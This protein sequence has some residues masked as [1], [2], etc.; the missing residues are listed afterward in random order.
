[1]KLSSNPS[2]AVALALMAGTP[3]HAFTPRA[4]LT[5]D[6][7]AG[8]HGSM[9]QPLAA[10]L[11]DTV[12]PDHDDSQN[13]NEKGKSTDPTPALFNFFQDSNQ[14]NAA[15]ATAAL[16]TALSMAPMSSDAAMTGGR[17]GGA[18]FSS[19]PA[20]SRPAPS[21]SRGYY[22][23]GYYSRP[24]VIAPMPF[25]APIS[26]F[27]SP[28]RYGAPGVISYSRG[29]GILPLLVLGGMA[30]TVSNAIGN[31]FSRGASFF[32][33]RETDS[34]LGGGTSV[35][36]LSVAISVADRDDPNSILK[37]LERLADTA[38]T[39]SRV[40][41]Q[42]LSSQ[43]AVEL[44]R[45]KASVVAGATD[46]QHYRNRDKAQR[47]FNSL[48]VEERGKFEQ[49]TISKF[50]GVDYASNSRVQSFGAA[51]GSKATMA[52]VTLCLAIDGDKT[53]VPAIR[54]MRD[55][56][57][58]LRKIASDAK[59]SD[60]LQGAEILWTP[61]DSSESLTFRDVVADYPELNS[62]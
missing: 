46:Y 51:D 15:V 28:Y 23:G 62:V 3:L 43:I 17:I 9:K 14:R 20:M 56:E 4:P 49:E 29:P 7:R 47:A 27:Y 1:M 13:Q 42:N 52:V 53:K 35:L 21:A 12:Q 25:V 30:L 10:P 31:T 41:I 55:I 39:D 33:E 38:K 22:S 34:V 45:R 11:W 6:T 8:L 36:K 19:R 54:N 2:I 50:G 18:S 61:Q 32:E 26:P 58:A 40:G 5:V 48:S 57:E 37:V 60:C 59:V 16:V 44:L 24:T